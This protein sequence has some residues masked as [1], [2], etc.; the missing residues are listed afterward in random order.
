MQYYNVN[1]EAVDLEAMPYFGVHTKWGGE[2]HFARPSYRGGRPAAERGRPS[3]RLIAP[4]FRQ[5]DCVVS[6]L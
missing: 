5:K 2:T 4:C 1:L 3:G 6:H